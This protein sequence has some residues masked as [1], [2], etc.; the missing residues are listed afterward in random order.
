MDQELSAKLQMWQE[1][2]LKADA[3][4]ALEMTLRKE[5]LS[6]A[7]PDGKI[8]TNTMDLAA[9]WKL[10]GTFKLNY[11]FDEAALD[12]VLSVLANEHQVQTDT[13]VRT[14]REP[15]M[16]HIKALSD[17]LRLIL[18]EVLISKPGTPEL[19]LVPPKEKK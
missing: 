18:D 12:A 3:A 4:K 17:E 6:L 9:D 19:K 15:A 10:R 5:C 16:T 13:L 2:K 7:F 14:K 1:A 11:S 8:G